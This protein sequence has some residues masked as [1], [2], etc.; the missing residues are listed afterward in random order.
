MKP[1]VGVSCGMEDESGREWMRLPLAY[2]DAVAKGG[3][4][5]AVLRVFRNAAEVRESL[6]RVSAV[7]IIG[8]KDMNPERYG[9]KKHPSTDTMNPLREE[10]DF[11]LIREVLRLNMPL[12]AICHGAQLLNVALGGD[13]IQHVPEMVPHAFE[14]R[15]LFEGRDSLHRVT[16]FKPS[17]LAA[18]VRKGT[19]EVNSAH[20]QAIGSVAERLVVT[21]RSNDGVIEAVEFPGEAFVVGLQ[22]HPER[23]CERPEQLGILKGFIAAARKAVRHSK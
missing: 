9:Q 5:P 23:I 2:C 4:V 14:H 21:A 6:E 22:W 3:G 7:V 18:I 11:L 17:R 10:S 19:M 8:G 1:L 20:H 16:V 15:A 12:L 13:L